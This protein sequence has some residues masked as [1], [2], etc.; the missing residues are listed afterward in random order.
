MKFES[1][2]RSQKQKARSGKPERAF[3]FWF[4][5]EDHQEREAETT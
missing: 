3:C 2:Q 1:S 4:L 5:L